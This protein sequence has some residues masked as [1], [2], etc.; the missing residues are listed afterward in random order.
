MMKLATI[1]DQSTLYNIFKQNKSI[2]PHIRT[3]YLKRQVNRKN[4]IFDDGVVIVKNEYKRQVTLNKKIFKKGTYIIH[5]IVNSIKGNG[6]AENILT[7]FLLDLQL[8]GVEKC[9]LTVRESNIRARRFYK[10]LG[11]RKVDTISWSNNKIKGIVY[12]ISLT[13][14]RMIGISIEML[15]SYRNKG[16]EINDTIRKAG[17]DS[18]LRNIYKVIR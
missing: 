9:I 4:V 12:S 2:F 7:R 10:R 16:V 17:A 13:P 15:R 18:F 5:Q 1:K 14:K 8:N 6:V 11:F 3:D